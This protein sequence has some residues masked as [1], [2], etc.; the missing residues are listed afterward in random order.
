MAVVIRFAPTGMT[1]SIYDEIGKRL[2]DAGQGSPPGRLYHVCFGDT[3]NLRVSDIWDTRENFAT[4]TQTLGPILA[5]LGIEGEPEILEV[6]NTIEGVK[7]ASTA[8]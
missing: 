4:F 8:G 3:N 2:E 7:A 6:Y 5:D 1:N